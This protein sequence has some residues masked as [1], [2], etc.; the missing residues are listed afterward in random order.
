MLIRSRDKKNIYNFD[1][2][3]EIGIETIGDKGT[4]IFGDTHHKLGAYSTPEKAIKVLDMIQE[5]YLEASY[6]R[7]MFGENLYAK[8][9][10]APRNV[11]FQMPADEEVEV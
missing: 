8:E 4:F 1:N 9:E 11:V 10:C 6:R 7:K 3:T 5:T 2:I